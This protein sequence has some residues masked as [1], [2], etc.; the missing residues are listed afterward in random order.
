[1]A[2]LTA[3]CDAGSSPQGENKAHCGPV[4]L[5]ML[6]CDGVLVDSE[7]IVCKTYWQILAAEGYSADLVRFMQRF[8]GVREERILA[9]LS[10]ELQ[11]EIRFTAT[12]LRESAFNALESDLPKGSAFAPIVEEAAVPVCIASNSDRKRLQ[13]CVERSGLSQLLEGRVFSADDVASPKPAPDLFS[14]AA[15]ICDVSPADCLVVEDS[16]AGIKAAVSF[17]GRAVGFAYRTLPPRHAS[18]LLG[19]GAER[20]VAD[21]RDLLDLLNR[22]RAGRDE[23]GMATG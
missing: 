21:P 19:V 2:R 9:T 8:S 20:L 11:R 13:L 6:D 18:D 10:L 14:H 1:M 5:L 17:G 12:E 22:P 3:G 15:G 16:I 23:S 7:P 4:K